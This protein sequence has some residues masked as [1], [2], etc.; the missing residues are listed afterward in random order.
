MDSQGTSTQ[1]SM[2]DLHGSGG[3]PENIV[4][5]GEK[6]RRERDAC[7]INTVLQQSAERDTI[8]RAHVC[9]DDGRSFFSDPP[10]RLPRR[11]YRRR[12]PR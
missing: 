11:P 1:T 4:N 6:I 3:G 9:A 8:G 10:K 2:E 5:C 7:G 12:E